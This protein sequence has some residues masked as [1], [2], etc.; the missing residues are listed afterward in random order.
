MIGKSRIIQNI[1]IGAIASLYSSS[2]NSSELWDNSVKDDLE[3]GTNQD[4]AKALKK[5]VFRNV[6][7]LSKRNG[8]NN[9]SL[10]SA[11][12][13]HSSHSSHRSSSRMYTPRSSKPSKS[14]SSSGAT[15]ESSN[16]SDI[17]SKSPNS[18]GTSSI[19][20]NENTA[21]TYDTYELGDR[22]ITLNDYGN[23][24]NELIE[25]LNG[26]GFPPNPKKLKKSDDTSFFTSDIEVA[27]KLFQA[28][29]GLTPTG[30][31]DDET[32]AKLRRTNK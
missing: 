5:R 3:N 16:A 1:I 10:I 27:V 30:I 8:I 17:V 25:L 18:N 26:A 24:V 7:K 29:N 21:K 13:S 11:H 28:Y 14:S 6:L 20:S 31:V 2:A 4:M 15:S 19:V 32:I 9:V 23:D 22:N 12:N